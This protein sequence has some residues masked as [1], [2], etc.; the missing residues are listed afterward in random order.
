MPTDLFEKPATVEDVVREVSRIKST[1]T[2]AVEEGVH[3]AMRAYKQ[4]R[5]AAED[6]LHD[7]QRAVKRNPVQALG[8]VLGAGILI[9]SLV[10]WMATR[11]S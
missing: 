4:G 2:D 11:R 5:N 1:V 9:G 8:I 3:S 7:A 6:A 10:G